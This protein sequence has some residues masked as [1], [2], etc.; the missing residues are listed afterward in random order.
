[1]TD[2]HTDLLRFQQLRENFD[3]DYP[4]DEPTAEE[5]RRMLASPSNFGAQAEWREKLD[6]G[7][8]VGPVILTR[9]S[10]NR[11]KAN[12]IALRRELKALTAAGILT[13][14]DRWEIFGAGHWAVGW[15]DHLSFLVRDPES[16]ALTN[17]A[18][19]VI[20]WF[21]YLR[22]VH[23]VAD[24]SLL[25]EMACEATHENVAQIAR[26]FTPSWAD[27]LDCVSS[28]IVHWLDR[29]GKLGDE[30][31][32]GAWPAD[33]DVKLAVRALTLKWHGRAKRIACGVAAFIGGA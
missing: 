21:R 1:M 23:P 29:H 17:E 4:D 11:E 24:E 27:R 16:N 3:R 30:G 9:D 12:N 33:G 25:S 8:C 28:D 15:V 10:E 6:A 32:E 18:R 19:F 5:E 22:E 26:R 13:H 14:E 31:D 2:E 20:G 7:W